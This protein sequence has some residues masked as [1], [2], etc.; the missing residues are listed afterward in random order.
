MGAGNI[1][2][3]SIRPAD[4]ATQGDLM[5]STLGR[6]AFLKTSA[7]SLTA[8]SSLAHAAP[9]AA[10]SWQAAPSKEWPAYGGDQGASRYSPLEQLTPANIRN[11]KV[12]WVHHTEDASERPATT[13]ETTPIVVGGVMYIQTAK[14]QVRA[15]NA[16]NGEVLWSFNPFE[17]STQRR[18]AGVS[19]GV[20][21]WQD[22][23]G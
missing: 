9:A 1:Q 4:R 19:R 23:E 12:A 11:L 18:A 20:C 5:P 7:A 3:S 8:L 14:L 22:E 13:I 15:L 21:Y 17:G 2:R 16:A 6:R 10:P